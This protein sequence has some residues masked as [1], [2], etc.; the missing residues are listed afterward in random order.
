MT[1]EREAELREAVARAI[2][3]AWL[4]GPK[5]VDAEFMRAAILKD[6]AK[7]AIDTLRTIG[8]LADEWCFDME[9]APTDN[10]H[11]LMFW[12]PSDE[13]PAAMVKYMSVPEWSGFVFAEELINDAYPLGPDRPLAWRIINQ[14]NFPT[15]RTGP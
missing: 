14:P 12:S 10:N 15:E 11:P 4:G 6:T 1:P 5:N 7:T 8:A 9:K 2:A 3:E 13:N